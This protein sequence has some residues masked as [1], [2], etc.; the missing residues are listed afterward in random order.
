M[1]IKIDHIALSP[2]DPGRAVPVL[3]MNG[4]KTAFSSSNMQNPRIKKGLMEVF[5]I[6]NSLTMMQSDAG[7]P[8]EIVDHGR[9]NEKNGGIFFP[10]ALQGDYF[11]P[12]MV[13]V[14]GHA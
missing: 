12:K 4:Y 7:A 2:R 11:L 3:E 5:G 10:I 6:H 14:N 13:H 8:I 9:V 1:I